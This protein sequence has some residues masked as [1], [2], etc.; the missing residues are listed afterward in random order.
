MQEN[1][2]YR[3]RAKVGDATEN[4]INVKLDQHYDMFEILSL[5]IDQENF[6]KTYESGYGVIVGR[7]IANGGFG[8]PNAK[9]SVFIESDGNDDIETRIY[10]PYKSPS[11]KNAD[12]VRYNLL[13]DFLDKAC[14]QN[15]GTFPNKRLVLDNDD[16][17][18]V[19]DKYYRYTTVTNNA[20]DYMIFGVPTG[21][22]RLHVDVDLS[23]I[24]MLSQ[25]PRDMVYKGY[26]IN[27]FE[28]PNKFRQDK[29]LN[30]L[31][32]ILTQ[33]IGVYVY[34]YWGDTSDDTDNI[35]VTRADIQLDYK[36]EPTCVFIGSII[37]DTGSNAIGKNCTS[38]EKVGKMSELIAGEGSIE[39]IRKTYDG[40]VEEFQVKGNRVIDGDGV[41]CYQIPMNLDYIMTDEFGNIAPSDNPEK[42]I[43][44]RTRVRF[45]I[46]LDDAPDDNTARKRCR[47]LV[48]NNPR[49]DE[50]HFPQFTKTKEPDYEFGSRTREESYKDLLWNKVYTVKNYVPRLQKNRRVTDRKHTGI[51]LINHHEGNNPMPYNNV[52]IKLGFTYR[53]LCVIFKIFINLVQFLNQILTAI[54]LAFCA[55]YKVFNEIANK[56]CFKILGVK[57][58][59]WMAWPFRKLADLFKALIVP[60]V[61]IGS[62]MCGGNTTHNYTFYPGCGNLMF[63]GKSAG[64]LASCI[65]DK[66]RESHDKKEDKRIKNGEI[67]ASE[68]TVAL[69]G[70]TEELYNC[71][72][73]ALAED[74]DTISLNFQNDWV[75]GTLYAP[76]W[77]RKITKKRSYLFGLIKRRAKDQWCEG[78]KNYTRKIL[79]V[80][81]PC[82]PKRPGRVNY[83]NFDGKSV[84]AHYMNFSDDKRFADSCRDNCHES[85][86]AINLDKGLIVKRQTMLGQDVY[87]YKPVEFGSP[88]ESLIENSD[89][90][91]VGEQGFDSGSLKLLFATDIVLL[92]SLNDCDIHGVPQFYKSLESTTFQ[93]PPNILFTDNEIIVEMSKGSA[94]NANDE[95]PD[96]VKIEYT[97]TEQ[98]T[99][100]MTGMDWGNFNE[101]I[102]GRWSDPQD[103]G[104]F[105]SIGCSTVKMKP[106]SCINMTRICEF[107][108]S[109][110]ETTSFIKND[111]SVTGEDTPID[112]VLYDTITPDGFISKDELYNDDE[113]S[114]FATLNINGLDTS[115]NSENGL[116]EYT[117]KHV[118]VDNFDKSLYAY[119]FERQSR[120][121]LPQKFNYMLEE[122]SK[123]YY[124]FRMGKNPYFY[125]KEY[126]FPRYENSF[127]FYFGL[128]PGKTAI[129]KF[130]SQFTSECTN[131][132]ENLDPIDIEAVGNTWCSEMWG[133]G[134]G[135]VA[136]NL[137]YIDLPCD[138]VITNVSD[139]S[140]GEV[141]FTNVEDEM[142]YVSRVPRPEL[143]EKGYVR[144]EISKEYTNAQ[145]TNFTLTYFLNGVYD[146]VVT[147][148]NGEIIMTSF[149]MK[150]DQIKSYIVG[151]DFTEA[152]NVLLK[153]FNNECNIAANK[154]CLPA[155]A[156]LN[157]NSTRGIGGTIAIS[158]PY[159]S[160]T[161]E[162]IE[163]FKI[164][165]VLVGSDPMQSFL[166]TY[167]NGRIQYSGGNCISLLGNNKDVFVFGV[168]RGDETYRVTIT[169][170]CCKTSCSNCDDS[171]NIYSEDVR[172]KSLENFKL[173]INGTVDYDVIKH[174][175]S[176]FDCNTETRTVTPSGNISENWWHMTRQENYL[177]FNYE[178]YNDIDKDIVQLIGFYNNAVDAITDAG[179]GDLYNSLKDSTY[180]N[181]RNSSLSLGSFLRKSD[182][183]VLNYNDNEYAWTP[184][185]NSDWED[186]YDVYGGETGYIA[187]ENERLAGAVSDILNEPEVGGEYTNINTGDTVDW[188]YYMGLSDADK[189]N[190]THKT[191][192]DLYL[193]LRNKGYVTD[194]ADFVNK[195]EN[196]EMCKIENDDCKQI[197]NKSD[198][199]D[200]YY[201]NINDETDVLT[202]QEYDS[203]GYVNVN[204]PDDE[205]TQSEY[206]D[207]EYVYR[208]NSEYTVSQSEYDNGRLGYVDIN[209]PTHVI[210]DYEYDNALTY[211]LETSR[212][213]SDPDDLITEEN[214]PSVL[215]RYAEYD[216]LGYV[217]V[218]NGV[219]K[220]YVTQSDY[221]NN[222]L[223][224]TYGECGFS[225]TGNYICKY[226]FNSGY[227]LDS[228]NEITSS[229][230]MNL[231]YVH[232][233]DIEIYK[234]S[235]PD[236]LV[237][238]Y[239]WLAMSESEQ[240]QYAIDEGI[241]EALYL[242][243][244]FYNDSTYDFDLAL[245]YNT[246]RKL[247]QYEYTPLK[248]Y[249]SSEQ[250]NYRPLL[251]S[252]F[253]SLRDNYRSLKDDYVL[254]DDDD[255]Y[256]AMTFAEVLDCWYDDD[257]I[258]NTTETTK[259]QIE[260][261]FNGL[262][263]VNDEIIE[264]L[265]EVSELKREF[266]SETKKAFQLGCPNDEKNI[267]FVAQTKH[268][269]VTYYGLYKPEM[270]EYDDNDVAYYTVECE[271]QYTTE[272]ESIDMITIP[273]ITHKDSEDFGTDE[274][275]TVHNGLPSDLCYA[276]D[277]LSGCDKRQ[278]RKYC[279]FVA[280]RNRRG[281]RI[282]NDVLPKEANVCPDSIPESVDLRSKL[283]G[284]H[285]IDKIFNKAT[286]TWVPVDN[287]PY[288]KPVSGG[289]IDEEKAGISMC[290]NGLFTG[291]IYN[292]NVTEDIPLG[293]TCSH[294]METI[295]PQQLVG[296]NVMTIYTA[297]GEGETIEDAEDKM[298]TRR[299]IVGSS[300][301][302]NN[303]MP[304]ENFRVTKDGN[305]TQEDSDNAELWN[306]CQ[307][308][309]QY[310]PVVK[311]G[312]EVILEDESACQLI[313]TIDGR[314]KI[315][316]DSTSVNLSSVKKKNRRNGCKL[317]VKLQNTG[318][319][320]E[321][322]FLVFSAK[323]ENGA[324]EYPLNLTER[325]TPVYYTKETSEGAFIDLVDGGL[326]DLDENGEFIHPEATQYYFG[327]GRDTQITPDNYSIIIDDYAL[328]PEDREESVY[329]MVDADTFD[330]L[331]AAEKEGFVKLDESGCRKVK[332]DCD[333]GLSGPK[334][335][336]DDIRNLFSYYN[337]IRGYRNILNPFARLTGLQQSFGDK[338]TATELSSKYVVDEDNEFRTYGFGSTG[339]F[340][341]NDIDGLDD[342]YY[343]IAITNNNVRAISP[344]YD[345]PYVC[346]KLIF[347]I[348]YSKNETVDE[349]GM[350][351]GYEYIESYR[352]TFDIANVVIDPNWCDETPVTIPTDCVQPDKVLYYF[353]YYPYDI[354]FECKLDEGVTI[355]GSYRHPAY[356][357]NPYGYELF[358]MD[359]ATYDSLYGIYRG[360]NQK[361]GSKIRGNTKIMAKDY[362]GLNHDVD[363]YGCKKSDVA[364]RYG[365]GLPYE[366]NIW[367]EI[368]WVTNG[369]TWKKTEPENC[370]YYVDADCGCDASADCYY[371][372]ESDFVRTFKKGDTYHPYHVGTLEKENCGEDGGFKG[373]A[374][375]YDSMDTIDPA[376]PDITL[377]GVQNESMI[378][379]A[380]WECDFVTVT[381]KDCNG[382]VISEE[383]VRKGIVYMKDDM[384]KSETPSVVFVAWRLEGEDEDIDFEPNGYTI[385]GDTVF[386]ARCG[387]ECR[388]M[389]DFYNCVDVRPYK[390]GI[391]YMKL[392]VWESEGA[393][394]NGDDPIRTVD[395]TWGPVHGIGSPDDP[396]VSNN[397]VY[398]IHPT[399]YP[400][401]SYVTMDIV[402]VELVGG[403]ESGCFIYSDGE[404]YNCP[405]DTG[406][407]CELAKT[408]CGNT[409][410]MIT[411][412]M[413]IT[414]RCS[415]LVFKAVLTQNNEDC[416]C[417]TMYTVKWLK[418]CPT[419]D[420]YFTN[421]V[422]IGDYISLPQRNP[423]KDG[424][425]FKEWN[426][427]HNGD[428]IMSRVSSTT[429][430]DNGVIT[431]C[432]V[433]EGDP[434]TTHTVEFYAGNLHLTDYDT[435]VQNGEYLE[436]SDI[437]SDNHIIV[438]AGKTWD[439]KWTYTVDVGGGV[440]VGSD[441]YTRDEIHENISIT[442]NTRFV[443]EFVDEQQPTDK[444][445]HYS[446]QNSME[447]TYGQSAPDSVKPT[448]K[449]VKPTS[450]FET[451][452][453]VVDMPSGPGIVRKTLEIEYQFEYIQLM[454]VAGFTED[455]AEY[456]FGFGQD[457]GKYYFN[458]YYGD[459]QITSLNNTYSFADYEDEKEIKIVLKDDGNTPPEPTFYTVTFDWGWPAYTSQ[460]I[461]DNNP[462]PAN[463]TIYPGEHISNPGI[464]PSV[465]NHQFYGWVC[466]QDPDKVVVPTSGI[467]GIDVESDLDFVG[468]WKDHIVYQIINNTDFE[469][470]NHVSYEL[471]VTVS[472]TN[473]II[474]DSEDLGM[475]DDSVENYHD[476]TSAYFYPAEVGFPENYAWQ[477]LKV[478]SVTFRPSNS[479][480]FITLN[481]TSDDGTLKVGTY[482]S[483]TA[484][485]ETSLSVSNF[486]H[487]NKMY[488]RIDKLETPKVTASI[489]VM[490]L[491]GDAYF[492]RKPYTTRQV[493]KDTN[494]SF[495]ESDMTQ[496][497]SVVNSGT[498]G[499]YRFY[500]WENS[501][502]P[503]GYY[504]STNEDFTAI[505]DINLFVLTY[506]YDN[507]NPPAVTQPSW[508]TVIVLPQA[509]TRS[510]YVF[511]GWKLYGTD[512]IYDAGDT[513][514]E[515]R[516]NLTF[517]AQWREEEVITHTVTFRVRDDDAGTILGTF[518]PIIVDDGHVLTNDEIPTEQEIL[519]KTGNPDAY[520]FDVWRKGGN[521]ANFENP[522]TA[523]TTFTALVYK[524]SYEVKYV[525]NNGTG[526]VYVVRP[527]PTYGEN[528]TIM[529]GPT[530]DGYNFAGWLCANDGQTYYEGNIY[531]NITENLTFTAQWTQVAPTTHTVRFVF[532]HGIDDVVM[533]VE[534][535]ST[536]TPPADPGLDGY[537]LNGWSSNPNAP[538]TQDM[539]FTAI[540]KIRVIFK[541][542]GSTIDT[543]YVYENGNVTI[544]T[545]TVGTG[546]RF[547]D[548]WTKEGHSTQYTSETVAGWAIQEP[549]VLVAVI[550]DVYT[551]EFYVYNNGTESR[552]GNVHTVESGN[553]VTPP[554]DTA[555]S[556]AISGTG[557]SRFSQ[558]TPWRISNANGTFNTYADTYATTWF[559]NGITSNMKFFLR[560]AYSVTFNFDQPTL[561]N[562][563]QTI[564][565]GHHATVPTPGAVENCT[566]TGNWNSSVSGLAT[567]SAI[568]A[569]VTFTALWNCQE[570]VTPYHV[571]FYDNDTLIGT[572]N[573][574]PGN[575]IGS[576]GTI[577]TASGQNFIGWVYFLNNERKSTKTIAEVNSFTPQSD[578]VFRALYRRNYTINYRIQNEF[579]SQ[580]D[581]RSFPTQLVLTFAYALGNNPQMYEE[582]TINNIPS[583]G[584][585]ISGNFTISNF[586]FVF[587]D[588]FKGYNP[589][590][591]PFDDLG[592]GWYTIGADMQNFAYY[593]MVYSDGYS[594]TT[595]NPDAADDNVVI[596]FRLLDEI[597]HNIT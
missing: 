66:T 178:P 456:S 108:V 234:I 132:N 140:F 547:K 107:G 206:D 294:M 28:S 131:P 583:R 218:C 168:P 136:F 232:G 328:P 518:D 478:K 450:S 13:T 350:V 153:Q 469:T 7:V 364:K 29:N 42:G 33:D 88:Q 366:Y 549:L 329:R 255:D 123:G 577:P 592:D 472:G 170:M 64:G 82:S 542:E 519:D 260:G 142:F 306:N 582:I 310:T 233:A 378:Y 307:M 251:R 198:A 96:N 590:T 454:S 416:S 462:N 499:K 159:N 423:T 17:I 250:D 21:S 271:Y 175:K 72:E 585:S 188:L 119:M 5:K 115:R 420:L 47:Y 442:V 36:F 348:V 263:S 30:S 122:F 173:F 573:V 475:G 207:L 252:D 26:N 161:G 266:V 90:F 580:T 102:C 58:L 185:L 398:D 303:A 382:N 157:I 523:D 312:I 480:T 299:Y 363:W 432:A 532:G 54:S 566:F 135:Y 565:Q 164:E 298:P 551:V 4:V 156:N 295:F 527:Y 591:Y 213:P 358:S 435:T 277:N 451:F 376:S 387:S 209:D 446:I 343:V 61:A 289:C 216:S 403:N 154:D 379:Y 269:P 452:E 389:V 237:D 356:R 520:Y 587:V 281:R 212:L 76:M 236:V 283:F 554:N 208:Y 247:L 228:L 180:A 556:N 63:S 111:V 226:Q 477:S 204:D 326:F 567:D 525:H 62:D 223:G 507:G 419:G 193:E 386:V 222:N 287:V 261:V 79:R 335:F 138:I 87:Y 374:T 248:S 227:G 309:Q 112:N 19:F 162:A 184:K 44:T 341:F 406:G 331:P 584:G 427:G 97:V 118:V 333:M 73:T 543:Q 576:S 506:V 274:A 15:V 75:N 439:G 273:T 380:V 413:T 391:V 541:A 14:Y 561:E 238:V 448:F 217:Y 464:S 89:D 572:I 441:K 124:D 461:I 508:G 361:V 575:T 332:F 411:G 78:E 369:G 51:K 314:M 517:T 589:N 443:A 550:V 564:E 463:Q 455:D 440:Y 538:I 71:V 560:T 485:S 530:Y 92:G 45:R 65:K 355:S 128:N 471:Q 431:I 50:E 302:D 202:P 447:G 424:E 259:E 68:R 116:M 460:D 588:Q 246:T 531:R 114:L 479:T 145:G 503:N 311:K 245:L 152:N 490:G 375:S 425:V 197:V 282:P 32:Q 39:M 52:D 494:L 569:N 493:D 436:L 426:D 337:N 349:N 437:P 546:R 595:Y 249:Y 313:D 402:G 498:P 347:G 373:W 103:S 98:S 545:V 201:V 11:S 544:P 187:Q 104:L 291:K 141:S 505:Y 3:I 125:D 239:D 488:I 278:R 241:F 257:D 315:T 444:I 220:N 231:G 80:F 151:T 536:V 458:L 510:G 596:V 397:A 417:S 18:D 6:Y 466:V 174:W 522:I 548:K 91:A 486:M 552:I 77:F 357:S 16:V 574:T 171:N 344:V 562:V 408:L 215:T 268:K 410:I 200:I 321:W 393:K 265:S 421:Y 31:A 533:T 491:P 515:I 511:T 334:L 365:C 513:Y 100:E 521:P 83:D 399:A 578:C 105:Y 470:I 535:G 434:S 67:D 106:K 190:Y 176:G 487:G 555:I 177:W 34:P 383:K 322:L 43:P 501:K 476:T 457:S 196:G 497:T 262:I 301:S 509:P 352:A 559:S 256:T 148:N 353:F 484:T 319:A 129:D 160:R 211:H 293:G 55:I 284:Y 392:R 275:D 570:P 418:D 304:Y 143:E 48:P 24:G 430:N 172:I 557:M 121:G 489:Y 586:D 359:K 93:M 537:Q 191:Q 199:G 568:T 360:S 130:N 267:F 23:D 339:E 492:E 109:L 8:V 150:A 305:G 22:Q 99:S 258:E 144:Y 377:Q 127:Y 163:S 324:I 219:I 540:W 428:I 405:D 308:R 581:Q 59:C 37:T 516:S 179:Y 368:V 12:G 449:V 276:Y 429:P 534:H 394:D 467:S 558:S 242:D 192:Y 317:N 203:L 214:A 316:L 370:D 41:W 117:F 10:Y 563:T 407:V 253:I 84:T 371:G 327:N 338:P 320:D 134:D 594:G 345:F 235:D 254:A 38:T 512:D 422:C 1:S 297:I 342:S 221:N 155:N 473:S 195:M 465:A 502:A 137:S 579:T 468:V 49:L 597:E 94:N 395:I 229:D 296:S 133:E 474:V 279:Y 288:F 110:D 412:G 224:Y 445:V 167:C 101:D 388:P 230:Y 280:V 504:M 113:R 415:D 27:Q 496:M 285:I 53:L 25:R 539:T 396:R 270:M 46:S 95:D 210:N 120:C 340:T 528:V 336:N 438:P 243:R 74:N 147:D 169:E 481:P 56:L 189:A 404:M 372:T 459:T 524:N 69:L 292:G 323:G 86:K 182:I 70:G 529:A 526:T 183:T 205:I 9:V 20:G 286:M 385:D 351:N 194:Y 553:T 158:M 35:A 500:N 85:T 40:K 126:K 165:I 139:T 166:V 514:G 433:W 367:V 300:N 244:H 149:T 593:K 272:G 495:T 571:L 264:L 290:M 400:E 414:D 330:S 453:P 401:G 354:S 225:D 240:Q 483:A 57:P 318:N 60:C 346:A 186:N 381:F 81:N 362:V 2:T 146:V 409:D 482:A 181:K 384:P 325:A 390:I